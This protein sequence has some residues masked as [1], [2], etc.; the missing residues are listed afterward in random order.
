VTLTATLTGLELD[1]LRERR[2]VKWT[3]YDDDVLPSWVAEMDFPLAGPVKAALHGA[4]DRDDAGYA[5]PFACGLPEALTGFLGRRQDWSADPEQVIATGDVVGGLTHLLR[6]LLDRGDRVVVTPPVYHPFF[7]LVPDAGCAIAEVPLLGGRDLDLDG[8]G[9]AFAGGARAILLCNPHNPTGTVASRA[10]LT[11]LARLADDHG[12]WVL[13]D[14]IHAPLVLP[15]AEHVPFLTVSE[16]AAARGIA[17]VSASKAF[18]LAGLGCAQIVT[19]S[20]P[21]RSAAAAL[22]FAARHCGHLGA[23]ASAAAYRSGDGWLDDVL[24]VLDHNRGLVGELLA[25]LLP[26]A[27]YEPPAAGYLAWIDLS[28]YDLGADPAAPILERGRVAFSSGPM[29]GRGGEGHVRLNAGTSPDLV[30]AMVE[31]MAE[32]VGA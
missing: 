24:A 16:Q 20:D 27:R 13:A 28:V 25:D 14:E 29:F 5:N 1:R 10:E 4:I 12:A 23:I 21:A 22:P 30:R 18:N 26:E 9:S 6:T 15:G 31:R 2:S 11:E 3:T 7:S 8:I 17:L 32:A 19:A